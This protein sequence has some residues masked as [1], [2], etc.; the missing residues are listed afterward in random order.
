[1]IGDQQDMQVRLRTVLPA[2]WFPDSAPI[3]DSILSG[4]ASGWSWL[5]GLL[6]YVRNQTRIATASDIWL[7]LIALDF[8]GSRFVR[9]PNEGDNAFRGRIRLELFRERGTRNAI[10]AALQDVTGRP[11]TIFEPARPGDTG[12]YG[13]LAGAGGGLGYSAA[14]GWG[15]LNLP[16]QCLITAYR[17]A[18]SG[19]GTVAGWGNSAG[20]Y[21]AGTIE[22]A[23][24]A[25]V[26]GQVTDAAI[27]AAVA[28]VLPVASIG[29][30]SITD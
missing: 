4:L 20:G 24:L 10:N 9:W 12:A 16:F 14:G 8:L 26:Q 23:S 27:Y 6:Q 25:M 1:M 22:Y 29:W 7:D 21:G 17:P 11:P 2:R 3:L 18:G 30:T 5:H 13:S 28:G 15:S 19:I